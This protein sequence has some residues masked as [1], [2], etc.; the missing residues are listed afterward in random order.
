MSVEDARVAFIA[1]KIA[2][3]FGLDLDVA[4]ASLSP[5]HGA[6]G[7]FFKADG[8][9]KLIFLHQA[10]PISHWSPYDRV[11]VVNADPRGLSLPAHLSAQG[12]S[13]VSI[14]THLDVYQ[15]R[16]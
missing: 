16:F 5:H 4:N 10:R 15:L 2:E 14:P 13:L 12:P 6:L 3:C 1:D 7:E 9:P 11:G 8:P